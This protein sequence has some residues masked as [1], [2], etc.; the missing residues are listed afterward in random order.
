MMSFHFVFSAFSFS[1]HYSLRVRHA[2]NRGVVAE[3]QG[4]MAHPKIQIV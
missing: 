3:G 2:V 4:A 1:M